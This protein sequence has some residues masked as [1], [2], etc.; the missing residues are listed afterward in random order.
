[1]TTIEIKPGFMTAACYEPRKTPNPRIITMRRSSPK[2]E[3]SL[4]LQ[5]QITSQTHLQLLV[6]NKKHEF[7][8]FVTRE[9]ILDEEYWAAAWLRAE[10]HWENRAE[11]R[12]ADSYKKKFTEQ[13][14]NALKRQSEIKLGQKSACIVTVKK[15]HRHEK[16]AVLKSVVGTLDVSI[17]PFLHGETF[18]GEKIKAHILHTMER[19]EPRSQYGYVANLCVAKFARRQGIARNML[20]FAIDS[21][22]SDGLKSLISSS[23][24]PVA[25][26]DVQIA[27]DDD[28]LNADQRRRRRIPFRVRSR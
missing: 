19:K 2:Q 21:A 15:G 16:H 20:H 1:M 23:P 8:Q 12:F 6:Q 27:A 14:F 13:E 11:D 7:G 28:V 26:D 10:T 18:P 17:R 22:I 3:L 5:K 4:Q 24:N 25:P 9:A